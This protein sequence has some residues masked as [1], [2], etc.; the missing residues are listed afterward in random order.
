LE[1]IPNCINS[2]TNL[3]RLI[4]K[5]NKIKL[6][7][8]QD[9][10]KLNN[11]TYLDI[12]QNEIEEIEDDIFKTVN[13]I[14]E[15]IMHENELVELPNSIINLQKCYLIDIPFNKIKYLP[16]EFGNLTSLSKVFLFFIFLNKLKKRYLYNIKK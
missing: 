3:K 13:N 15:L 4:L 6:I 1:K 2:Q 5:F 12:S 14:S 8:N 11:L 10:D 9:M 16:D 7:K